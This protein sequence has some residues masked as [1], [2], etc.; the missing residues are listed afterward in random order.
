MISNFQGGN[1][2]KITHFWQAS[3]WYSN[4]FVLFHIRVELFFIEC[5]CVSILDDKS[6]IWNAIVNYWKF[7][8]LSLTFQLEVIRNMSSLHFFNWSISAKF[9]RNNHTFHFFNSPMNNFWESPY[10]QPA[11]EMMIIMKL[12]NDSWQS[13]TSYWYIPMR[14]NSSSGMK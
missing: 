5:F 9:I 10:S 4:L 6:S 8:I 7:D 13:K 11:C 14:R 1:L 12:N 3:S 2:I